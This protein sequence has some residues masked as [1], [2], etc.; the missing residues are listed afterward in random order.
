M[1][2]T[3]ISI[4]NP[5][6]ATMMMAALL[7]LGVFASQ[8]LSVE[9]F[10]DVSFPVVVVQTEYPGASPEA[11][12]TD[13]TRRIEEAVNTISGVKTLS[14]RSY[15]GQSVVIVEF[16]LTINPAL[17]A[18]D[19]RERVAA[20]RATFRKEIKEPRVSRFNP[21]D[22]PILSVAVRSEG[23]SLRELTTLTEQV[24]KKR[25]ENVRGVGRATTVGG[26]KREIQIFIKPGEMEAFGIG[27]DQLI[28]AI[29]TENQ[30]LPA[31]SLVTRDREQLVQVQ[32]RI[33]RPEQFR[34]I[35]VA[36]RGGQPVLLSQVA[37]VVDGQEEEESVAM[38][39]GKRV[40]AID[41][42][43]AQDANTIDV[44]DAVQKS[45][46][47]LEKRLPKDVRL[48]VVRNTS[49]GIRN[50]VNDVKHTLIEG[51]VLTILIV[52]LFLNSWRSTVI[53]GLTLPIALI[54]TF[55]VMYAFGFSINVLTLMAM[56]LCVGLLIDDAIVVRENIVRHL[57]MG[58]THRQ[59]ALDGTREIGLAV[60]ATT[61]TIVAVFLPVGFMGGIIGRFFHQFGIT[62]AAAVLLSMFVSFT[63]DPMLSAVW[64]DP[65][66]H[67]IHGKGRLARFLA[68][69]ER[70]VERA[71]MHYQRL[72]GWALEHRKTVIALALASF[73][74]SFALMPWIGSE[75][76]PEADLGEVMV[77]LSTPVGSSLEF[78][79]G[80]VQQA[81][82]AL[83]EFREVR[84]TYA[85]VNTG[86]ALGKNYATIFVK[87]VERSE[88]STNQKALQKPFRERLARIAGIEVTNVGV[89]QAVGSGKPLQ[90]SIQGQDIQELD[91]LAR[92]VMTMMRSLPGVVDVDSSQKAAKPTLAVRLNREL[93][94]DLGVGVDRIGAAL[95]PLLAGEAASTWKAPDDEIYDVKVRLA[96][97]ERNTASDLERIYV[98]SN[99][100]NADGSPKMIALRQVA[101]FVATT[102]ATQINRKDLTREVLVT[103][104]AF[105]KPAGDLGKDI[106]AE[107][108][109]ISL[110][111][112]Y[113]FVMGGST[114]DIQETMGYALT[115][116]AL[117]V[118]FIYLIL[119]SQ[120]ASFL[121]PLAIMASLPLSLVGVLLALLLARSTLNI[122]SIIGFVMLMGLVTKNAILLVD[123]I[124]QALASGKDRVTAIIEAGRVRLRPIVMT[125]LAMIFGMIPLAL[126]L[127]EGSEQRAPMA[128]AVIGGLITSTLLTLIVV[129]VLYTYLDDLGA[130][131][132]RR[133][134]S[135]TV[136]AAP[137][138]GELAETPMAGK[139]SIA[140]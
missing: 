90:V 103:A 33:G 91:R 127:G 41:I 3:R 37:T 27:V 80:K 108:T 106:K 40:L 31:G 8:R 77:Q 62:V 98:A 67:G 35:I 55:L 30:E 64:Y 88:R 135:G 45:I 38:V 109:R 34:G 44:V 94:S 114:K 120:F 10:P 4:A 136:P 48:E 56:S 24:I 105:G 139:E 28:N 32:G 84:Y 123:F 11:V 81:E 132:K 140:Q 36:R 75:F 138:A 1:W 17:A 110:Q 7:V 22:L 128:H 131:M 87:L 113:R 66:A 20:I 26:V 133:L 19:V 14:S 102:G 99:L 39:D 5:V 51:A 126:G 95:R 15:E 12:E 72:L 104:N 93:A 16:D 52:F 119:A 53:T 6:L 21:D 54:G 50:S 115:A 60:M 73:F 57:A 118:V 29:R 83:R 69:N 117:G 49:Q 42:V 100:L 130:W 134:S 25:I 63:L 86:T 97:V 70:L 92:Q 43:K 71:G 137:I 13:I 125:T 46:V 9:Q 101:E 74:G 129:P 76:V 121:Q 18:Q 79:Q 47:E 85:N 112:G 59:A 111:P 68:L 116:L 2:F 107:L 89:F 124:N 58:K 96:K 61:F 23:K 78:T 82:A 65:A 122:F